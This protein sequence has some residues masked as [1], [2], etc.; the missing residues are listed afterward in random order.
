MT[1]ASAN[2]QQYPKVGTTGFIVGYDG[3]KPGKKPRRRGWVVPAEGLGEVPR[4][5]DN[6]D[7][8]EAALG[9]Q[10]VGTGLMGGDR[11]V[12][13]VFHVRV[14]FNLLFDGHVGYYSTREDAPLRDAYVAKWG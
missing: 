7:S 10:R 14:R 2:R 5:Y 11:V 12:L 8:A 3:S 4:I 13:R 1:S 6:A 9:G